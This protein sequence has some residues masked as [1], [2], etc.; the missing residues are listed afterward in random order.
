KYLA[1]QQPALAELTLRQ[2]LEKQPKAALLWAAL[3]DVAARQKQWPAADRM[4]AEARRAAGDGVNLRLAEVRLWTQARA[5][6]VLAA[7]DGKQAAAL[8]ADLRRIEGEG[9]LF[10]RAC[11][12]EM[13]LTQSPPGDRSP[14]PRARRLLAELAK[15]HKTWSRLAWL[16]GL[17]VEREANVS[18]AL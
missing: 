13:L 2:A 17:L 7:R 3:V 14:L 18:Q 11:E 12:V 9:G 1:Q 8:A 10:W 16:Q 4:L 15:R 6:K 5:V